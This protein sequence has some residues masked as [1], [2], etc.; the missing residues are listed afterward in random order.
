[1][2]KVGGREAFYSPMVRTPS[3]NES[4][5]VNCDLHK[6]F[7]SHPHL[8]PTHTHLHQVGSNDGRT[9]ELGISLSTGHLGSEKALA[10]K[11]PL[12]ARPASFSPPPAGGIKGYSFHIHCK[13]HGQFL[14]KNV[15]ALL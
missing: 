5:P 1:M 15:V 6:S 14:D 12:K 10:G 2:V 7:S 8:P 13:D 4:V 9:L 3:C 11:V